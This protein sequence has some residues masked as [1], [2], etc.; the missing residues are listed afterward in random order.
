M[1]QYIR[2]N[3]KTVIKTYLSAENVA[4]VKTFFMNANHSIHYTSISLLQKHVEPHTTTASKIF[5][6]HQNADVYF[7][8]K[9]TQQLR[10]LCIY[11][12]N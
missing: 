11:R 4:S 3:S 9:F 6:P 2:E 7:K 12:L 1:V 5:K 8:L 10:H